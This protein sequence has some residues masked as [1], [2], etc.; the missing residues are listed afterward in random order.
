[1]IERAFDLSFGPDGPI[2]ARLGADDLSFTYDAR[3]GEVRTC[4]GGDVLG[5]DPFAVLDGLLDGDPDTVWVGWFGYAANPDLPAR[6]AGH[7]V[8]DAM[9]MRTHLPRPRSLAPQSRSPAR[10]SRSIARAVRQGPPPRWYL[11]GFT[12]VQRRLR[13]GDSYE[14]NLTMR[15]EIRS[16][17]DPSHAY[18]QLC[19]VAP[20]APYAGLVRHGDTWLLS[21]SPE[22]YARIDGRSL[23]TRPIKGTTP[24]SG[25]LAQDRAAAQR[26]A[27]EPRFRAE[28]LMIAD[29]AR[30]DVGRVSEVG[31][32]EVP[33]LMVV[34][35]HAAVHQL[36]TTVRGRIRPEVT[37]VQ[38]LR[39]LFPA[40][41]MTGAPKQRTM[42]I[43]EAVEGSPR[44]VY[45]GA[46]GWVSGDGRADL[47]VVIR[48]LVRTPAGPWLLG[49]GGGITV[50]SDPVSEWEE[51]AVKVGRLAAILG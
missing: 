32:V 45:A 48:S 23:L 33:E 50:H 1:M 49:T 14:V 29:L 42:E 40:G 12:E 5:E 41:S 34:E 51:A 2:A 15:S 4:P 24:R 13:A 19:A 26:L 28:N 16:A 18:E 31:S 11:D 17:L 9:W 20:G 47:A 6:P 3:A 21:A 46:Y 22:T 30:N 38:A 37:T 25:D 35:P 10:E 7:G 27:A 39:A 8:P 43:I 36:V 44:G